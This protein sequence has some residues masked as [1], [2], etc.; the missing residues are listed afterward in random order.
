MSEVDLRGDQI[1]VPSGRESDTCG[2]TN[3]SLNSENRNLEVVL[4]ARL[5]SQ[6]DSNFGG[7]GVVKT[8]GCL[9]THCGTC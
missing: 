1:G 8:I 7:K 4:I 3:L 6:V 9:W 2:T 5:R